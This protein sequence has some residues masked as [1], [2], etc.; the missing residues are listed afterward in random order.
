VNEECILTVVHKEIYVETAFATD[1]QT[2]YYQTYMQGFLNS[3]L[4]YSTFAMI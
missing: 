2:S 4:N 3:S 1:T